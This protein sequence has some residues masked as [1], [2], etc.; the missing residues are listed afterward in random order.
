MEVLEEVDEVVRELKRMPCVVVYFFDEPYQTRS[1][2]CESCESLFEVLPPSDF[3]EDL[4]SGLAFLLCTTFAC[5][6]LKIL[7]QLLQLYASEN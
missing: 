2:S 5:L 4:P 3:Y 1:R 6:V 7:Y